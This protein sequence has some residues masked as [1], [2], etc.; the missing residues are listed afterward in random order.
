M[1]QE[2]SS[3]MHKSNVLRSIL[4][5]EKTIWKQLG[6]DPGTNSIQNQFLDDVCLSYDWPGLALILGLNYLDKKDL[7][8]AKAWMKY[9]SEIG[10][11]EGYLNLATEIYASKLPML[12][13]GSTFKGVEPNT[14]LEKVYLHR[15]AAKGNDVAML[16]L[17]EIAFQLEKN[18]PDAIRYWRMGVAKGNAECALAMAFYF[19]IYRHNVKDSLLWFLRAWK[20]RQK[21]G[22]RW[23]YTNREFWPKALNA[24]QTRQLEMVAIKFGNQKFKTKDYP[25]LTL[26]L[27]RWV[28]PCL[29]FYKDFFRGHMR[30][31]A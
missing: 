22:A 23:I 8:S 29:R 6:L 30:I 25:Y 24:K 7:E 15:A 10:G 31:N 14:V 9:A 11:G 12:R 1:V 16:L 26:Q 28:R 13:A 21:N 4:L 19:A 18:A 2:E 5:G 17:G 27:I 20:L 3:N